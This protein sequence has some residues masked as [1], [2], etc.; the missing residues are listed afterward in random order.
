MRLNITLLQQEACDDLLYCM[1]QAQGYRL[2]AD[3]PKTLILNLTRKRN[4]YWSDCT[5]HF[6]DY[7]NITQLNQCLQQRIYALYTEENKFLTYF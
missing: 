4:L 2:R 7:V 1:L 3:T 5:L 6:K